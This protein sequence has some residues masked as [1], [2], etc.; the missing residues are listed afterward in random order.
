MQAPA[1]VP[2]ADGGTTVA[3]CSSL[4]G[5]AYGVGGS[6]ATGLAGRQSATAAMGGCGPVR[7]VTLRAAP[8]MDAAS[9]GGADAAPSLRY[10]TLVRKVWL[11]QEVASS[12]VV[13]R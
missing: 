11:A 5:G 2:L 7:V 1:A 13:S 9:R 8:W 6:A 4:G 10:K 3:A 12:S